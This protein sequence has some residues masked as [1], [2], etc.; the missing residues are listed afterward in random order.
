[1]KLDA[2]GFPDGSSLLDLER[3]HCKVGSGLRRDDLIGTWRLESL[4][5]K[6]RSQPSQVA[7]AA[8]RAL[9]A[10]LNLQPAAEDGL[11]LSN[12][13]ALGP[14][15]LCFHGTAELRGRR[16]LLVFAFQAMELSL[17]GQTLWSRTLAKP[18]KGREPFFALIASQRTSAAEQPWLAA[19][20][21]G[22]GMALWVRERD[23]SP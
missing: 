1:M 16:P 14:L 6:G 22:G 4:W 17:A 8:L 7:G 3:T 18:A 20:G 11:R 21:R 2:P 19:R 15:Q 12:T 23:G 9:S 5:N 13:I 10:C